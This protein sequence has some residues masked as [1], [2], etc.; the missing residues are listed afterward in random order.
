MPFFFFPFLFRK[1]VAT[2]MLKILQGEGALANSVCSNRFQLFQ[3]VSV[4]TEI[5]RFLTLIAR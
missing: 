3:C 1:V 2:Y 4:V 5:I